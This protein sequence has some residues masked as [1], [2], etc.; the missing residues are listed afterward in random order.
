MRTLFLILLWSLVGAV[1]AKPPNI[2]L[3]LADDMGFSDV[4]CYG[5]EIETPNLDK[6]AAK[7]L[8]FSQFYNA[9]RCCPTRAAL[10]TGLYPHRAGVGHM[11]R[12][13][14]PPSYTGG[15]GANTATLAELLRPA[16]YRNYHAGKWHVGGVRRK[17]GVNHPMNRGFHRAYGTAGGGNYF[18]LKRLFLDREPVQAGEGYYA[19]DA[20]SD[21]AV[22]FLDE[23]AKEHSTQP[24]FLHLCY[25]A[26]H[27]PLHAKPADIAKYRG[28]YRAGW[29]ALRIARFKRQQKLSLFPKGTKLSARDSVAEAWAKVSEKEKDE[30]DLRMTVHAAMIDCMDQGIGRVMQKVQRMGAWDNTLFLFLSDNGA[31]AEA[32]DTWPNPSRGHKPGSVTGTRES[33]RCIEVGWSNASNTPFREHKMWVHEGGSATPLIAHWP[34][35][36]RARGQWTD[37]VGHVIDFAPTFLELAGIKYPMQRKDVPLLPLAGQSLVTT[38]QGKG[39]NP[40]TLA[41]EHEGNRA[42]RAGN[43]KLVATLRG[44]WELFNLAEDRTE[45]R[46]LVSA[47]SDKVRELSA[48]WQR[49]ADKVGVV[50]WEKLP[51]P[52]YTPTKRY[53]KKSEPFD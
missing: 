51:A 15:L 3:I 16:G 20:F 34:K 4:G 33:H 23:H 13:M 46:N 18:E 45:T 25:T 10:L 28:K 32:L 9:A 53:R 21:W 35:G 22:K 40:R 26:P 17:P 48:Q 24:F 36:I 37:A 5:G 30:W 38:F 14:H 42:I 29:D 31:S 52:D 47:H 6:L 49:W 44:E 8:R 2:V 27:F 7:G 41:W 12:P 39:L 50:P 11:L 43:W 1:H 19:T